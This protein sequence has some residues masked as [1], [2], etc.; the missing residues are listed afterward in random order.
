MRIQ[1]RPR[2]NDRGW[3]GGRFGP[4]PR[5]RVRRRVPLGARPT[6]M[7]ARGRRGGGFPIWL[8]IVLLIALGV[9]LWLFLKGDVFSNDST[10]STGSG[11]TAGGAE[12]PGPAASGTITVGGDD[13]LALAADGSGALLDREGETVTADGVVVQSV[14]GSGVVWVGTDV[15]H[16]ILVVPGPSGSASAPPIGAGERISFHGTLQPLPADFADRYGI[17]AAADSELLTAQGHV[18]ET[19][20]LQQT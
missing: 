17:S 19:D 13:L 18:V 15:D 6:Y 8:G 7:P 1:D 14:V 16:R 4:G 20:Q 2:R 3:R 5:R 9:I 12:A 10:A 11:T